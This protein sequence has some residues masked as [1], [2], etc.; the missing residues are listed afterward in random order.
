MDIK[1]ISPANADVTV[2]EI[3]GR[4]DGQTAKILEDELMTLV[5]TCY[6]RLVC[7]LGKLE[8]LGAAGLQ[9][10]KDAATQARSQRG[11][12]KLCCVP[13]SMQKDLRSIGFSVLYERVDEAVAAFG[14]SASK[15]RPPKLSEEDLRSPTLLVAPRVAHSPED[16]YAPTILGPGP[17]PVDLAAPTTFVPRSPQVDLEAPTMLMPEGSGR[18]AKNVVD[19]APCYTVKYYPCGRMS[20]G[21]LGKICYDVEEKYGETTTRRVALQYIDA[22]HA[23][24]RETMALLTQELGKVTFAAHQN[25]AMVYP[26]LP[27]GDGY[28][29]PMEYVEG[30]SLSQVMAQLRRLN[31]SVPPAIA[32]YVIYYLCSALNYLNG[33]VKMLQAL[34]EVAHGAISPANV[35]I[36]RDG[37]VKLLALGIAHVGLRLELQESGQVSQE[38][39]PYV[40]PEVLLTKTPGKAGDIFSLGVIFYEMLTG[41]KPACPPQIAIRPQDS[42]DSV[43]RINTDALG[44]IVGKCLARDVGQRFTDFADIALV[45][46]ETLDARELSFMAQPALSRFCKDNKFW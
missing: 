3:N 17:A 31:R 5:K 18:R 43:S 4:L 7:Q 35:V 46:A 45:L 32:C 20:D 1:T 38:L 2:L 14:G 11:D 13:A 12:V 30:I 26:R 36:T 22:R 23:Q 29:V 33:R 41:G 15:A 21:Y 34:P 28:C 44:K 37:N 10:F 16:L 19:E 24:N 8:F 40:A 6:H 27:A 39:R 42:A 25:L 9:I